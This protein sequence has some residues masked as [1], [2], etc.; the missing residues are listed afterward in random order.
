MLDNPEAVAALI[1]AAGTVLAAVIAAVAA[2]L[3]GKRILGREKLQ[4]DLDRAIKDIHF[5]LEVEKRH[6]EIRKEQG[7]NN[8]FLTVRS[9]VTDQRGESWSGRFTPGREGKRVKA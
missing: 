5:L 2:A 3:I 1:T 7:E 6:C 4:A 9:Y 8:N